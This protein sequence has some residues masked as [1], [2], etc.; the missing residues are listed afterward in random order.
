MHK[1]KKIISICSLIIASTACSNMQEGS[2]K[3]SWQYLLDDDLSVWETW[4]GVP[5]SSVKDLPAG[6]YQADNLN[7]GGDPSVA[8][9]LNNDVKNVFTMIEQDGEP[10]LHISGEIYGGLTTKAEFENY[11]LSLQVKWGDK[12]WAPRLNAKRDSGLL[13]HCKGEHGAFWKVWKACQELQI[14]ESDFGDYI[15]LAGPTGTIKSK[16]LEGD[17][18]YHPDGAYDRLVTGYS[19]A[20]IEPDK[21]HGEWNTVE[22]Y[23]YNDDAV[24]VVNSEVVMVVENSR[25]KNGD[26]LTS[27]QI[28]LQSEGAELFYKDIKVRSIKQIPSAIIKEARL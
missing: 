6:T 28:Q 11:H 22:L 23:V 27:G 5:H 21:A 10:V 26:L 17:F 3:M 15:P 9:G 25:D 4:N 7:V 1:Y 24:F 14:Q 19:H 18:K 13:Y 12:K 8:M 2:S 16:S 20:Y